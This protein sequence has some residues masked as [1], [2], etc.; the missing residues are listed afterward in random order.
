M[1]RYFTPAERGGG[2]G[3]ERRMKLAMPL[4]TMDVFSITT[5]LKTT[6]PCV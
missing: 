3:G 4:A 1:Q 2:D 6:E 5:T